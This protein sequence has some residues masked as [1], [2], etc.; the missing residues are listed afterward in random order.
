MRCHHYCN[1]PF[2]CHTCYVEF[3]RW[4]QARTNSSPGRRVRNGVR[5]REA[6]GPNFYACVNVISPPVQVGEES[7]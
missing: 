2:R 1:E 7:R 6:G 3:L 5:T 4:A